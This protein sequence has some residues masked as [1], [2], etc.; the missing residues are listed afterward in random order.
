MT[1]PKV[2]K[3]D[4]LIVSLIGLAL[5]QWPVG[6]TLAQ[7]VVPSGSENTWG[8]E[9]ERQQRV[10]Q[11]VAEE[12]K[13]QKL[14]GVTIGVI[15]NGQVV[16]VKGY[17]WA[18]REAEVEMKPSTVINWASNSKPL[19]AVIAA[20]L[21][22]EGRLDLDADIR[23]Y[24]PDFPDKGHPLTTRQLLCHQSGFPHYSNGKIIPG[25][26]LASR[27]SDPATIQ[28]AEK[29]ETNQ[30]AITP[31]LADLDP[32]IAVRRFVNSPLLH[33]PGDV[34]DY[35][36]YAYILLSAVLQAAGNES[37]HRQVQ[38]RIAEPM[39]LTSLQLDIPL[40]TPHS[41]QQGLWARGYRQL[42]SGAIRSVP[43]VAH[44]WKYGA[45]GYKSDSRDFSRWA[46]GLLGDDLMDSKSKQDF[47]RPQV[48]ADGK[49]GSYGLGF[50]VDGEGERRR[51]AHNGSQDE[52]K[53]RLVLY[54][55]QRRGVV[56]MSN[57]NH[58]DVGRV[59][60]AIFGALQ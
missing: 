44:Y 34:E 40:Q 16:Y 4:R 51:V 25:E 45:G 7:T 18:D 31:D 15:E 55:E 5:L 32:A 1:M 27:F 37:W 8:L 57:C 20:Q 9:L 22:R 52:T 24:V 10:D 53:T 46:A 60:T 56:V 54:P 36:S 17:G 26:A 42:E 12:M 21:V 11:A 19:A 2:T 59:T 14:V 13:R 30:Q 3:A 33:V 28:Q 6:F 39:K 35:S 50:T 43:D 47:W 38:R 58:A 41:L 29:P 48:L 49:V 23:Q